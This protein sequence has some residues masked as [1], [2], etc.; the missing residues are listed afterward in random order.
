M[1]YRYRLLPGGY[2]DET[3]PHRGAPPTEEDFKRIELMMMHRQLFIPTD[4]EKP[5][6][7]TPI[8]G[9]KDK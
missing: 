4:T 9:E 6:W 8:P 1:T 2:I 7:D 5:W 3:G